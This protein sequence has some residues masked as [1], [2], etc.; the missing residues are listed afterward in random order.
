MQI[1][2]AAKIITREYA[3]SAITPRIIFRIRLDILNIRILDI[4]IPSGIKR[5]VNKRSKLLSLKIWG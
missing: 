4:I 1:K 5:Q 3:I 2:N